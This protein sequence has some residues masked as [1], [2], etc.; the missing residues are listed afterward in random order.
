MAAQFF[1][2]FSDVTAPH[3]YVCLSVSAIC[4]C[5]KMANASKCVKYIKYKEEFT[6]GNRDSIAQIPLDSSR[7]VSTRSTRRTCLVV[8]RRDEPS[9]IWAY[10]SLSLSE[11]T[12]VFH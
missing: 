2:W 9:G 8:S 6:G 7:H 12:I 4:R 1:A 10:L 5:W 3:E 11:I